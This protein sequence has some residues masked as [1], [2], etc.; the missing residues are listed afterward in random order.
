MLPAGQGRNLR[1]MLGLSAAAVLF[2]A[3]ASVGI[4][5]GVGVP[6]LLQGGVAVVPLVVAGAVSA[7]ALAGTGVLTIGARAR[8]VRD[9]IIE[10]PDVVRKSRI[11]GWLLGTVL[12]AVGLV[13]VVAAVLYGVLHVRFAEM[14][15]GAGLLALVPIT[16]TLHTTYGRLHRLA[17]FVRSAEAAGTGGP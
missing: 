16:I 10:T 2:L 11:A 7:P 4:C 13:V 5:L 6:V 12:G 8:I 15:G 9:T 14:W 17:Q 1:T 3:V